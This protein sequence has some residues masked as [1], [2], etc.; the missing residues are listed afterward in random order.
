MNWQAYEIILT[1][2]IIKVSKAATIFNCDYYYIKA[3]KRLRFIQTHYS[4]ESAKL[5][6]FNLQFLILAVKTSQDYQY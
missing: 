3:L 1:D 5:R 4:E 6:V 2:L